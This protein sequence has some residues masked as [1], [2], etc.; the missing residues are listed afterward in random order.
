MPG[1]VLGVL[2]T[3]SGCLAWVFCG[4]SNNAGGDVSFPPLGHFPPIQTRYGALCLVLLHFFML[5][6]VNISGSPALC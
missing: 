3:R 4:T 2:H 5:G 1:S 6:T